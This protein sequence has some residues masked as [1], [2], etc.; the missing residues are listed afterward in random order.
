MLTLLLPQHSRV[1]RE[2][3]APSHLR[4]LLG[5]SCLVLKTLS[6]VQT[7]LRIIPLPQGASLSLTNCYHILTSRCNMWCL[8]TVTGSTCGVGCHGQLS[9][10][11]MEI[12][13]LK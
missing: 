1:S 10:S 8:R 4:A 11:S 5:C 2:N 12:C 9:R 6:L 3:M 13:I 7:G